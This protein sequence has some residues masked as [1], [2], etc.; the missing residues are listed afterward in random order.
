[1][2]EATALDTPLGIICGGGSIPL[3]VADSVIKSGRKVVLFPV[4]GWADASAF[5][6]YRHHWVNVGQLGRFYRL[7]AAEGIRD[8]V[9]VGT[10]L[11]PAINQIRLDWKTVSSFPRIVSAFRGGDDH[12]LTGIGRLMEDEGFRLIG[13]QEVAPQILMTEG[14]IGT[15]QPGDGDLNDIARGLEVLSALG[16]SDVGQA[17][18][19]AD[20]HVLA[21]EAA[22]GTDRMVARVSELRRIGRVKTP[23]GVGV[24][25]KAPKKS[26]DRRFDLPTVGPETVE[27]AA[28]AELAGVAIVAGAAIIVDPQRVARAADVAGIFVVGIPAG[29]SA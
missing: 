22:E 9:F 12:L 21:L 6:N 5:S 28:R 18:V 23:P 7:A 16:Q 20:G 8:L 14:S 17:V 27:A 10:V 29:T 2:S 11:R 19:V 24:L 15:R 3:T 4:A 26:Q 25:V 13:A 1:M